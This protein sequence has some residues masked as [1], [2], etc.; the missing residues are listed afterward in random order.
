MDI[1]LVLA[2]F[3]HHQRFPSMRSPIVQWTK[4]RIGEHLV[5]LP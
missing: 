4:D 1:E 3:R 5:Y 2:I